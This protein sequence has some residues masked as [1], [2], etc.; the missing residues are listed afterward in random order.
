[1]AIPTRMPMQV[2]RWWHVVSPIVVKITA[3]CVRVV[4]VAVRVVWITPTHTP[5]TG[6]HHQP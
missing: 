1:M 4:V 6:T 2:V 5:H 3:V